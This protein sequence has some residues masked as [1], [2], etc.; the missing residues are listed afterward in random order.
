MAGLLRVELNADRDRVRVCLGDRAHE[1][2]PAAARVLASELLAAADRVEH[3][4]AQ[5]ADP[6]PEKGGA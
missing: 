4:A 6:G 5:A 2:T 1:F 3:D